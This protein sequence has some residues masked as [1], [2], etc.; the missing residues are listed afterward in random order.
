[1]DS[2]NPENGRVP[3]PARATGLGTYQAGEL[4]RPGLSGP[5]EAQPGVPPSDNSLL[6]GPEV[7]R[8]TG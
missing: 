1:M 4:G 2:W 8:Q 5:L 7:G 3:K 6:Q